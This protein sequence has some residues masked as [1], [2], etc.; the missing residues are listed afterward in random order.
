M[1]PGF[2]DMEKSID[3]DLRKARHELGKVP[4][5]LGVFKNHEL[6]DLARLGNKQAEIGD[7]FK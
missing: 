1:I 6:D 3:S 4:F 7:C 2:L 5:S